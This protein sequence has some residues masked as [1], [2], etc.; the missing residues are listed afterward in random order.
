MIY[1]VAFAA[2]I[3]GVFGLTVLAA[4]CAPFIKYPSCGQYH[5]P[6]PTDGAVCR[7]CLDKDGSRFAEC[8][9]GRILP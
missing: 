7:E 9:L 6:R 8:H 4:G 1:R 3:A 5:I 2:L